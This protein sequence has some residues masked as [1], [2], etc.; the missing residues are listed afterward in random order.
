MSSGNYSFVDRISHLLMWV[1]IAVAAISGIIVLAGYLRYGTMNFNR[2]NM[3]LSLFVRF[4]I[5]AILVLVYRKIFIR[6]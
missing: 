1:A 2:D 6:K 3:A 5:F 4:S